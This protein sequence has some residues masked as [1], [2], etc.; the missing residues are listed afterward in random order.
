M[1]LR[2]VIL[3]TMT[4]LPGCVW[5]GPR[6]PSLPVTRKAAGADIK[7]MEEFPRPLERPVLVL[8]GWRSPHL[9]TALLET[10][11]CKATSGREQD[12]MSISYPLSASIDAIAERVVTKVQERW[13]SEEK[14]VTI[15]VDVV[16]FSMGG[17]VA[18]LAALPPS[19]EEARRLNIRRLFTLATPHRG[20]KLAS[21]I[22]PDAAARDMRP[23]SDL[24]ERLDHALE[25]A[26][27]DLLCYAHLN[28]R[29]VGATKSSPPGI[30]PIWVNGTIALSHFTIT[31]D[32]RIRADLARRLRGENPL[33][34]ATSEPPRD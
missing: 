20:A 9:I 5:V 10:R 1:G 26:D 33:A 24:L 13:P 16:A 22:A 18:R 23:G 2:M 25:A 27:Y 34:L 28:D 11:L 19:E 12:F 8:A 32:R 3:A 7:R 4:S 21:A 15:E 17:L 30:D 31:L 6:N 14:G 29:M